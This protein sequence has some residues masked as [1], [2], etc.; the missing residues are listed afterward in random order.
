[1]DVKQWPLFVVILLATGCS[2]TKNTTVRTAPSQLIGNAL[3]NA[4]FQYK[5]LMQNTAEGVMPYSYKNGK[6]R[7]TRSRGWTAGFY[8]GTLLYLHKATGDRSMYNE[9]LKRIVIMDSM[10][11]YTGNHDLGF[12]MYCSYGA[13]YSIDPQTS[14]KQILI[15]S[16]RSLAKRYNPRVEAIRSWGD[17]NDTEEFLVIIDNMM[18]LELLMWASKAT[19]DKSLRN[20]AIAHANTTIKNHFRPDNSSYHVVEY[21]PQTGAVVRKRTAQGAAD[22][23]AWA[24]GQAWGLYGYIMMYRETKNKRYLDMATK[25][26]AFVL[27][28]PNLPAD[29]IPYWDFNAPDIPNAPRDASSAAII[30]SAL[31]EL[32]EFSDRKLAEG[33][34]SAAEKIITTLSA[35]EYTA[36]G[37]QNGGFILKHS[38]ANLPRNVDVDGPLPYADYYYIEALLRYR[39]RFE[40]K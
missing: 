15:N 7:T 1:M 27:N 29:K 38:V 2:I 23:S 13:L 32:S 30:A 39:N 19:G 9:A 33:Y 31:I 12:M 40:M 11:Y 37:G 4:V 36:T 22:E 14:Y 35:P 10:Q 3:S 21:N 18:N 16:A 24:R 6:I 5:V 17:I 34:M 20:V 28:H 25:V 8:P 26:A